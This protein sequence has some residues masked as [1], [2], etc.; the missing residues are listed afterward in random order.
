M[1]DVEQQTELA[2]RGVTYVRALISAAE[3]AAI[4][5]RVWKFFGKRGI[6]RHDRA[7]WPPGGLMSGVQGLR[8]ASAPFSNAQ[9]YSIVDQLLGAN[10]WTKPRPGQALVTFPEPE[11]WQIPHNTWH[12]DVPARGPIDRY[13]AV[14]VLGFIATV[15][16]HGG[17]T[18][19]VEGSHELTRRMVAQR[20]GDAGQ[21]SDVRRRLA[22]RSAWFA[23]LGRAG[24]DRIAQFMTDGDEIDGVRVRVVEANGTAGDVCI[25]HPWMLHNIAKNC[26]DRPRMMMTQTFLRDGNAYYG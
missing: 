9:L 5:D 22:K 14:R 13:D 17:G 20:D 15:A 6:D 11:P 8:D 1:L 3:A 24:G 25:M 4:E 21:S 23:A 12:F 26:S 19:F 16:P 10:T 2:T 18:L 7:T